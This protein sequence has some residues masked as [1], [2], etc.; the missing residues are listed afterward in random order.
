MFLGAYSRHRQWNKED[1]RKMVWLDAATQIFF[2]YSLGLGTMVALGSYNKYKHNFVRDAVLFACANSGTSIY[3]GFVIFSVIGFMAGNQN[4][5]ISEVAASGPGL[6]FVVY[7]E[8]LAQM[9]A[10]PV[11]SVMFFFML[12][13]LGIDSEF[14]GVEGFVTAM[15]D[16]FPFT[17]RRG[18]RR[19]IFAALVCAGYCLLGLPMV[20]YVL[21]NE[22]ASNQTTR[23]SEDCFWFI[24]LPVKNL[25]LK[26][27]LL[28][29]RHA[30]VYIITGAKKMTQNFYEMS[31]WKLMN[32]YLILAWMFMTPVFTAS[33]FIFSIVK[34]EP[35]L[36]NDEYVY[37]RWGYAL[38]WS[39]AVSSM[40]VP[41][42]YFIYKFVIASKGSLKE[43]W[44]LLT[45]S[46]L[47]PRSYY[48]SEPEEVFGADG[49][50]EMTNSEHPPP[51]YPEVTGA[52]STF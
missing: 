9:P 49:S 27:C 1:S 39:M 2:S 46:T 38:G 4:K 30:K 8:G 37:P 40:I 15:V 26:N 5:D 17:F 31:S 33:I 50:L 52:N 12:I 28:N 35:L 6:A 44:T 45:T 25:T 13:L 42:T 36:Y 10:A 18:N 34:Y 41:P 23:L 51:S 21:I 20:T 29:L 7:P 32:P 11:W 19:E 22:S 48:S 47:E 14:V 3:A 16:L 43:R 24:K